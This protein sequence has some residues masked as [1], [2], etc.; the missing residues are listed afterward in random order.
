MTATSFVGFTTGTQVGFR[1]DGST[2]TGTPFVNGTVVPFT[3]D[4]NSNGSVIGFSFNQTDASKIAPGTDSNVLVIST[5]ATTFKAGNASVI[6]GGTATVASFQPTT[7]VPEPRFYSLLLF[8]G[9]FMG[10]V[11]YRKGLRAV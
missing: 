1:T 10:A 9:I 8:A 4:M 3:A 5:D 11:F 2:L 7:A 6:D